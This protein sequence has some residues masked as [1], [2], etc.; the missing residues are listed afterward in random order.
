MINKISLWFLI[1]SL[2]LTPGLIHVNTIMRSSEL[3]QGVWLAEEQ[4]EQQQLNQH[5]LKQST[6]SNLLNQ[7]PNI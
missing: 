6:L 5:F 1:G 3:I 4:I 7:S 2:P